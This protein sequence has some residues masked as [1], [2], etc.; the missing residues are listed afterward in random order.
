MP[1]LRRYDQRSSVKKQEVLQPF[2]RGNLQQTAPWDGEKMPGVIFS[3]KEHTYHLD[4]IAYPSVTTVL[5]AEG[6]IDARFYDD[7]S[8]ERGQFGHKATALHDLN[9]L[10]ED[11]LDPVL[12]PYLDAWK[13]FRSDTGFLP[14]SVEV[15]LV[16]TRY[17]FA[18]TPDRVGT[19]G[20]TSC[21]IIDLKL[22]KPEPWAAI[23]T[24]AY[25]LLIDS[26][27]KRAALHLM[28]DGRYRLYPHTDRQDAAI[29]QAA[30]ACYHWKRN[31]LKH[32]REAA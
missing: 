9:Q 3:E 30:L 24:A 29:F 31:N 14:S 20:D 15:P 10:D 28:G 2:V 19:F 7:W 11:A 23:Q 12:V 22:G 16:S 1:E 21:I 25:R 8:R 4:G 17:H 18:G 6:F 27:Y 26:P 32:L 13:R 5:S